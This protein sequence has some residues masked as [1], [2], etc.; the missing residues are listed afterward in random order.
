MTKYKIYQVDAFASA[1]FTGNPAAIMPLTGPALSDADMQAIAMENNLAE[2]A[3]FWP[4][5]DD[6]TFRLRWFTP[7]AEVP[8]CGHATLASAHILFQHLGYGANEI[9]FETLSG[10][11]TVLRKGDGYEMD[12]P[13]Q[14]VQHAFDKDAIT[15]IIGC[16][17]AEAYCMDPAPAGDHYILAVLPSA[18]DV[19]AAQLDL[20]ALTN[21]PAKLIITAPGDED[22]VDFVSRFFAPTIGVDEDPV[23]G[24][25]HCSLVPYWAA[26]LGKNDL[27]AYQASPRGG[28]VTCTFVDCPGGGNRVKLAGTAHT[29]LEG[30][31]YL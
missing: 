27:H 1:P 12:F 9:Q 8:L 22:G 30:E 16:D 18:A 14:P 11:L 10:R 21:F 20:R 3:Y 6:G 25:A 28:H 19:R 13:A 5:G 4:E 29:V 2:T 23:T 17:V 15:G 31:F 7:G 26:R 24:S